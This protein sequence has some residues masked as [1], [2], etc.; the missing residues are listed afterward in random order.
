MKIELR[1]D[2]VT[3]EG[4]INVT[5][6]ESKVLTDFDGSKFIEVIEPRTFDRAL[7]KGGEVAMLLNH[8]WSKQIGTRDRNVELFEDNI[9]LFFRA[10]ISDSETI[11]LAK[12]DKLVGCSFGFIEPKY[13]KRELRGGFEKRYIDDLNLLEVSILSDKKNP[14]YSGC[15]VYKRDNDE[16]IYTRMF[17]EPTKEE[18]IDYS[19]LENEIWLLKN[20]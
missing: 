17:N 20:K 7:G 14:A 19:I 15:S 4:Y 11:E 3:L 6:R 10:N 8:D 2:S 9:G 12:A 18:K 16:N 1:E 13:S 5:A